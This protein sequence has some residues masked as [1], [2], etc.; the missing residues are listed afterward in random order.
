MSLDKSTGVDD[1]Q[2]AKPNFLADNFLPL[3][4]TLSLPSCSFDL[5]V[6]LL[7]LVRVKASLV[8]LLHSDTAHQRRFAEPHSG[9]AADKTQG[10]DPPIHTE[11]RISEL[12]A[13]V[14]PT[15]WFHK[16]GWIEYRNIFKDCR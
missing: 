12:N 1:Q 14:L 3:R 13:R 2:L 7:H 5:G 9:V 4:S 10:S 8:L 15:L 16:R 11:T 6:G